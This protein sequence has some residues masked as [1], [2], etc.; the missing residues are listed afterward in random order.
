MELGPVVPGLQ[1]SLCHECLVADVLK[2]WACLR[3][4]LVPESCEIPP[5]GTGQGRILHE[6]TGQNQGSLSR[7]GGERKREKNPWIVEPIWMKFSV[8]NHLQQAFF[9]ADIFLT[10]QICQKPK[11]NMEQNTV[12]PCP[13][14]PNFGSHSCWTTHFSQKRLKAA[15]TVLGSKSRSAKHVTI[16]ESQVIVCRGRSF[17]WFQPVFILFFAHLQSF[18]GL[19]KNVSNSAE[20]CSWFCR[21]RSMPSLSFSHQNSLSDF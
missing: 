12:V 21:C 8:H 10:E 4:R 13:V 20:P 19:C 14:S 11:T 17:P 7:T 5:D 3:K 15:L 2:S 1:D 9:L 6:R 16:F 18:Y